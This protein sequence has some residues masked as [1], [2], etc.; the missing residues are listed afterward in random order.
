MGTT[1][2]LRRLVEDMQFLGNLRWKDYEVGEILRIVAGEDAG[3]DA[4]KAVWAERSTFKSADQVREQLLRRLR[5]AGFVYTY[6][7]RTLC[8]DALNRQLAR[9]ADLIWSLNR[10]ANGHGIDRCPERRAR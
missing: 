9:A 2:E 5:E 7:N 6:Q 1:D 4:L 10:R 3:Y 8:E